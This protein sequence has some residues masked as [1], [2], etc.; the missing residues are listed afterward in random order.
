MRTEFIRARQFYWKLM[1]LEKRFFRIWIWTKDLLPRHFIV[2]ILGK[3]MIVDCVWLE[4][5]CQSELSL[6][7]SNQPESARK[8]SIRLR[9]NT[10]FWLSAFQTQTTFFLY[11]VSLRNIALSNAC[12]WPLYKAMILFTC[13]APLAPI[14]A[15]SYKIPRINIMP[16]SVKD[17][18]S[19]EVDAFKGVSPRT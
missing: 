12:L 14:T 18:L 9:E 10:S 4:R 16:Q 17:L 2:D 15:K 19:Y 7:S 11:H 8:C 1:H 3:G 13:Q 6:S 5:C